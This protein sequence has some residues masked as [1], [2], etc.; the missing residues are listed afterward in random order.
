MSMKS[1]MLGALALLT[2]IGALFVIQSADQ[3]SPTADAATG[4]IAALN[5]GTCL[6]TDATVF[7]GDCKDGDDPRLSGGSGSES[8]E[9][10]E[11]IAE[12]STLYATYAHDPKTSGDDPR[13]ILMD[14]DLLKISITDTDRDKRTGV[15]IRGGSY[16]AEVADFLDDDVA[17]A[18]GKKIME[19]LEAAKLDYQR[20]DADAT[21]AVDD[22]VKLTHPN[23]AGITLVSAGTNATSSEIQSSGNVTLNFTRT[24]GQT[25]PFK[26][27]DFDVSNGAEVRFYGCLATGT[28]ATTCGGTDKKNLKDYITVDEDASNGEASGNTAPWL[29]VNASV[30]SG[31]T[32]IIEAIYYQTSNLENVVGGDAY[33]YCATEGY[34]LNE[35]DGVWTCDNT[36]TENVVET[37]DAAMRD[38]EMDVV[39]TD[40]EMDDNSALLV[41]AVADGNL[42]DQSVNLYLTETKRFNG[43]YQGYLRLTDASGDGSKTRATG[44]G[45]DDWGIEVRDGQAPTAND[46]G[47]AI[48]AVGVGPVTIEYRD[49]DGNKRELDIEIDVA[50][51]RINVTSPANGGS[52]GDQSPDFVG[53]LEDTDSGLADKSFRLVVDNKVDGQGMNDDFVLKNRAPSAD[54]VAGPT[55]KALTRIEDYVG[56]STTDQFGIVSSA[57]ELYDLG[58]DSC[59]NQ[60]QCYILAEEYDDGATNGTFDD[61]LRLD[62]QDAS[63]DVDT[64]DKEFQIDFQAFVMDMAGNIGFSDS[65]PANPLYIN[66]LGEAKADDRGHDGKKGAKHNV[67]GFYSAHIITLDEKD[68]E[69]ED[70]QTATGFYGLNADDKP[71]PDR[72]GVMVVFDGPIAASTVSTS[73]FSVEL[74]DGTA[75]NIID[76]HA[77]KN[78]AFLKLDAELASDAT[79][80]IDIVQGQKVED[81][82]GNE[83]F[84]REVDAFDA[85]DGISPKLT[86]TLSGGSGSG[87]GNEGP[88]KLTNDQITVHV[89]SDEALQGAPKISVVCS[90]L[91]WNKGGTADSMGRV[92]ENKVGSQH[93]I[94][95][96]VSNR[97]VSVA[98]VLDEDSDDP[99]TTKPSDTNTKAVGTYKYTCDYDA[100]EDDFEDEFIIVTPASGLSLPGQNWN[101]TW[102]R[103]ATP[104]T[105]TFLNDGMLTVVAYG[106]DRSRFE[107]GGKKNV[108]N[109]GSAS[110]EFKLDTV[111]PSPKSD[112]GGKLQPGDGEVSKEDRPHVLIEFNEGTTVT[113]DSVEVDGVEV[114]D[115]F[116]KPQMNRFIYWPES[117]SRGDHEVDVEASDAAG[118]ESK[119][120]YEFTVE[121]RGKFLIE[122]QA[123]WNA[124][125]VPADPVDTAIGSVFTDPAIETVIG[126]DTQG[127]RIA[128]RRD[129]VWES[130][131]QYGALNEIR[132][133][134]GYWVKSNAFIDQP[135]ALKGPISRSI[136]GAPTLIGIDTLPGWNFVGVIDQEGDQTEGDDFGTSLIDSQDN[137]VKAAEYLT[138]RYV[139][140]YTWDPTFSQFQTLRR[141][142][143]MT[144]GKGVWVYYPEA[145]GIAP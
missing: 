16:T 29:G 34:T 120:S 26:P 80:E 32:V 67:L 38:G 39:F 135:V 8:W 130:N 21:A 104:D 77:A 74:D 90:D 25:E 122:L 41:Q 131:H 47:A 3:N 89:S 63:G 71:V 27:G 46:N 40:D 15:L 144:I 2:L 121:A 96:Y 14:S 1:K 97:N 111:L 24:D 55:G 119:F 82:A 106:H 142:D 33:Y 66:A 112:P 132:A 136:S 36:M 123:G 76:A 56:Y 4:S 102:K 105:P 92:A 75:A 30:P 51:P 52:S 28:S 88:E 94:R 65:D 93:D 128:V 50:A 43:V 49:S 22:D 125:S 44:T 141:N 84:G 126:W 72:A 85:N 140:A 91:K 117:L 48:L 103:P 9:I 35:D 95:D 68:P 139:Q 101:Y 107:L 18:L 57:S 13:A 64:R 12:V 110:A 7:K 62:L 124:V 100:N 6:T 70:A 129:G 118:N 20:G 42:T 87:T 58:D 108:Q 133:K 61:D 53:T 60:D 145:G 31:M 10:R 73:T 114:A 98:G 54:Y 37:V 17:T 116:E 5:V 11:E 134:Y 45:R 78:Y 137:P 109:W 127:W 69:I 143:T 59:D 99:V 79:P 86:V 23:A 81:M 115:Q 138:D 19:D 83:T 113:L